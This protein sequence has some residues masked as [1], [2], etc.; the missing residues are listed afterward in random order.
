MGKDSA[1]G[2]GSPSR[3]L[4]LI[5]GALQDKTSSSH[6][7]ILALPPPPCLSPDPRTHQSSFLR[8]DAPLHE[9]RSP[10]GPEEMTQGPF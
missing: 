7:G 1:R 8:V 9:K 2:L 4:S 6:A 3:V 10:N 5:T